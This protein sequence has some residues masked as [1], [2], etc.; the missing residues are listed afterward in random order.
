LLSMDKDEIRTTL[1]DEVMPDIATPDDW[2]QVIAMREFRPWDENE[3]LFY[4]PIMLGDNRYVVTFDV[5][6]FLD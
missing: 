5:Q 1:L 2:E 6:R 3:F 4:R